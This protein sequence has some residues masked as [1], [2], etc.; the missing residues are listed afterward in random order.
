MALKSAIK[1]VIAEEPRKADTS[2]PMKKAFAAVLVEEAKEALLRT[3]PIIMLTLIRNP[4][5]TINMASKA[6]LVEEE[7]EKKGCKGRGE[8]TFGRKIY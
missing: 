7:M 8:F 4:D 2:M 5:M 1:A 6:G 3:Q